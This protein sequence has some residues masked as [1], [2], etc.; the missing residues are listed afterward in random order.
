MV[1]FEVSELLWLLRWIFDVDEE[2]SVPTWY[3][4][5][6]LLLTF[7][8]LW[9]NARA[10]CRAVGKLHW[11]RYGLAGGFLLFSVDEIAGVHGPLRTEPLLT[12]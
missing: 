9:I 2:E 11:R 1:H 5:R 4:A 12:P 6:A 7:S 3:S 10:G 8:M